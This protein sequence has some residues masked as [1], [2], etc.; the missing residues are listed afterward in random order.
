MAA[1]SLSGKILLLM[2]LTACLVWSRPVV[3]LAYCPWDECPA[4]DCWEAC[5]EQE[6]S[7][8]TDCWSYYH[9]D[10]PS[11]EGVD[12]QTCINDCARFEGDCEQACFD[13]AC[14]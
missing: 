11:C 5:Q 8:D 2:V 14:D 7:C 12:C 13:C 1:S 10:D 9:L 3:L 4:G 6:W